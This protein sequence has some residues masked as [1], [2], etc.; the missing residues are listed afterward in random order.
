MLGAVRGA[1]GDVMAKGRHPVLALF[2]DLDPADV[3][4]N[5]HPAK[6]EVRFRDSGRIGGLVVGAIRET[7]AKA[8]HRASAIVTTDAL[9][10]LGGGVDASHA[11][12]SY[13]PRVAAGFNGGATGYV[14]PSL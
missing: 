7:L 6:T 8:G 4:V 9:S 3:D 12:L 10:R 2:I 1:Y 13:G 14:T 11:S 5:V